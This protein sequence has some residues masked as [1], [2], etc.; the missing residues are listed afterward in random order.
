MDNEPLRG[1]S[2]EKVRVEELRIKDIRLWM[3]QYFCSLGFLSQNYLSKLSTFCGYKGIY[4]RVCEE[5]G[6]T[7]FLQNM[8]FWRLTCDWDESQV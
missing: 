2:M 3:S 1:M 5:C 8:V 6:K 4:S 7:F